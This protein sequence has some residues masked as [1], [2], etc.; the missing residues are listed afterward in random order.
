[1]R[2]ESHQTPVR[3]FGGFGRFRRSP[4][5]TVKLFISLGGD[6]PVAPD[7]NSPLIV[8][9][10]TAHRTNKDISCRPTS[11][12]ENLSVVHR[13]AALTRFRRSALLETLW[14][15]VRQHHCH[16]NT[17]APWPESALTL[18]LERRQQRVEAL[19]QVDHHCYA[20]AMTRLTTKS[21]TLKWARDARLLSGPKSKTK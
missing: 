10:C 9:V 7:A 21:N 4:K 20:S 12:C 14:V 1:M 11:K 5:E 2:C 8:F 17:S 13:L 16:F 6:P 18:L 3:G 19:L 15:K